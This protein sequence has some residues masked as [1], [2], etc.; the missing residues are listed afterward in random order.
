MSI[1][2]E[3]REYV[4]MFKDKVAAPATLRVI[5]DHI[6]AAHEREVE[7][8]QMNAICMPNHRVAL[9]M[10]ADGV[11]IDLGDEVYYIDNATEMH[12]THFTVTFFTLYKG[13][14]EVNNYKPSRLRHWDK[15]TVEELLLDFSDKVLDSGHQWGLDAEETIAEFAEGIREAVEHEWRR[16]EALSVLRR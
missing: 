12:E 7:A 3:L 16:V 9:P 2:D 6:D 14:W 4:D 10:D 13:G 1:T 5:A 15:S 8:A 11:P